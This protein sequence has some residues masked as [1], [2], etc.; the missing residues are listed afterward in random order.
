MSERM[1]H[2]IESKIST[3]RISDPDLIDSLLLHDVDELMYLAEI[4]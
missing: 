4:R 1:H 3:E 2:L